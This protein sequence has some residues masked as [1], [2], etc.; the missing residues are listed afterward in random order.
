VRRKNPGLIR[1]TA[2]FLAIALFQT[3]RGLYYLVRTL[4]PAPR[5][6]KSVGAVK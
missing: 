6:I 4:R 2:I 5:D 1:G 3:Q